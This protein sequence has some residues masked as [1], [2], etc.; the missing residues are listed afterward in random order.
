[1]GLQ[2]KGFKRDWWLFLL[3][4]FEQRYGGPTTFVWLQHTY[5]VS[6]RLLQETSNH[7]SD[8]AFIW[9]SENTY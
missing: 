2:D 1:M 9:A 4:Y 3:V 7:D 8:M 5:V 6:E